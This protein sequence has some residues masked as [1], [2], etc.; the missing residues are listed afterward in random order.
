MHPS[1]SDSSTGSVGSDL[2]S[3]IFSQ[4]NHISRFLEDNARSHRNDPCFQML[5]SFF[6]IFND[7]LRINFE[8]RNQ[9]I[10]ERS[11]HPLDQREF[12]TVKSSVDSFLADFSKVIGSPI[13]DLNSARRIFAAALENST[14]ISELSAERS[15]IEAENAVVEAKIKIKREALPT[16]SDDRELLAS[17]ISAA[18]SRIGDL[19]SQ[20]AVLK[21][22]IARAKEENE[23]V[24]AARASL[25]AMVDQRRS[26]AEAAKSEFI[27]KQRKQECLKEKLKQKIEELKRAKD[28]F[29]NDE[30]PLMRALEEAEVELRTIEE[31]AVRELE[32]LA[33]EKGT[34]ESTIEGLKIEMRDVEREKAELQAQIE[35]MQAKAEKAQQRTD[36]LRRARKEAKAELERLIDEEG[37]FLTDAQTPAQQMDFLTESIQGIEKAIGDRKDEIVGLRKANNRIR[38]MIRVNEEKIEELTKENGE[39][40]SSVERQHKEKVAI[41]AAVGEHDRKSAIYKSTMDEFQKLKTQLGLD[42]DVSPKDVVAHVVQLFRGKNAKP[43]RKRK[44]NNPITPA[45]ITSDLELL[46]NQLNAIHSQLDKQ[47]S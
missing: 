28:S 38:S 37:H 18:E 9:F 1:G 8:L 10:R 24:S 16:I 31:L 12:D 39:L 40:E 35:A 45:A 42:L 19:R 41:E 33:G 11:E 21:S 2:R 17:E 22:D 43:R 44:T 5:Q 36:E 27:A 30:I 29:K 3:S 6:A 46:C 25:L 26:A 47:L 23:R 7:Q 32:A 13:V 15:R 4:T 34:L 20:I 14:R